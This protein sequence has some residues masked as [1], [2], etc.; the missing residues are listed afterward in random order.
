MS[1]QEEGREWRLT[2][3]LNADD[4]VS[5]GDLEEDLRVMLG[6]FVEVYK[7]RCLKVNAGKSKVMVLGGEEGLECEVCVDRICLKR[8]SE[9]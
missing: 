6:R 4:L 1:S 9:F 5:C 8:V 3:I 7:R 2:G